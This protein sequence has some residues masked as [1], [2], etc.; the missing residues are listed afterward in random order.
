MITCRDLAE[1]LGDMVGGELAA[2][3]HAAVKQHLDGCHHCTVLMET[4]RLT[5]A[6]VGRLQPPPLPAGLID[7][8]RAHL[9]NDQPPAV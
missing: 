4:Y 2:D 3:H 1:A 7:R 8:L 9:A 6:L 5:I